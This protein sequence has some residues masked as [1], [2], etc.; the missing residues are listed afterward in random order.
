MTY[1]ASYAMKDYYLN[2]ALDSKDMKTQVIFNHMPEK[3]WD[4]DE[5]QADK[6]RKLETEKVKRI[7]KQNEN[8]FR[9]VN[10]NKYITRT[11]NLF[12][13]CSQSNNSLFFCSNTQS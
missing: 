10:G 3:V 7:S 5:P 6:K 11:D 8:E 4:D 2:V 12:P 13:I 1:Y 9:L